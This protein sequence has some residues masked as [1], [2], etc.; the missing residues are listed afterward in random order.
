VVDL[1]PGC[2]AKDTF[3][4]NLDPK[5]LPRGSFVSMRRRRDGDE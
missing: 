2:E 1:C 5:T 4:A 3:E